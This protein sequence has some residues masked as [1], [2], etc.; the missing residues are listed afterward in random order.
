VR[1]VDV[2]LDVAGL[3]EQIVITAKL[4]E[5]DQSSAAL[6]GRVEQRQ[7]AMAPLNGRNWASLLSLIPGAVDTGVSDQRSVRFAG[8]GRDDN[9]FTLDGVDA[10]GISNQPQKP[11]IRIAI[12]TSSIMEFKV[13]SSLFSAESGNGTGGQVTLASL[14]GTKT[15]HGSAFDFLRNEIFD[16]RNPFATAK[17]PF[18]LNQFGSSFGGP[19]VR[20]KTFL[21]LAFEG[22]GQRLGQ[23]LGPSPQK[24]LPC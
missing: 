3:A 15:F 12:P 11:G 13:D 14:G 5:V 24:R 8:H 22:L 21:F 7:L 4:S 2:S 16:A 10:G 18:R 9:N 6:G 17:P 1:T 19:L 23:T 20:G